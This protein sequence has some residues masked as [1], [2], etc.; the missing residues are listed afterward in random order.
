MYLW[1]DSSLKVISLINSQ[2]GGMAVARS[3]GFEI[4]FVRNPI[5]ESAVR[6]FVISLYSFLHPFLKSKFMKKISWH[7]ENFIL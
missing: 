4:D 6:F 2:A 1:T 7:Q 5:S 3:Y